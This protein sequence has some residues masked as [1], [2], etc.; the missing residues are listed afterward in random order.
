MGTRIVNNLSYS[1]L[2]LWYA[3]WGRRRKNSFRK[4]TE[5][6]GLPYESVFFLQD[7]DWTNKTISS[8]LG[9]RKKSI[10]LLSDPHFRELPNPAKCPCGKNVIHSNW[11]I[12][13]H[14]R[15]YFNQRLLDVDGHHPKSIKYFF[16][17]QYAT[18]SQ[19]IY[20]NIN[21]YVFRRAKA[22]GGDDWK[23][24][25]KEIK[26]VKSLR[27]FVRTD[28][29]YKLVQNSS[30]GVT[31]CCLI[32]CRDWEWQNNPTVAPACCKSWLKGAK[33]NISA[34]I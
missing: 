16:S 10:P 17:A 34:S 13:L 14:N 18:E 2:V 15:R 3:I 31:N 7:Q 30:F 8:V 33:P 5:L 6:C 25:P 4:C 24:T 9:E 12:H 28:Q 21:H 23:P 19:Q 11:E 1:I 20:G 29:A 26:N 22:N 27:N 32:L